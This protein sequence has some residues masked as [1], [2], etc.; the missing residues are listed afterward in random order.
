MPRITFRALSL[1][2][3]TLV[4]TQFAGAADS[5][6][7]EQQALMQSERDWATAWKAKDSK[8]VAASEAD[9]Y[10]FTNFD[11]TVTDKATDMAD[12]KSGT[13]ALIWEVDDMKA[14]VFGDTGVV[15]GRQTQKGTQEGNDISGVMRF[16]DTWVRRDGRWQCVASQITRIAKP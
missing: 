5:P 7:K 14:M 10:V 6:S 1:L 4:L 2:L 15:V 11:G 16:T 13:L 3:A 12:L 9:E 8:A